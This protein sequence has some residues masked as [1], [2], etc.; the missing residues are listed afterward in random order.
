MGV[1]RDLISRKTHI[2]N[3]KQSLVFDRI[4]G[5]LITIY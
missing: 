1:V 2:F 4:K 5:N 3:L